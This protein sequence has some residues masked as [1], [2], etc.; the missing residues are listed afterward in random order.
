MSH[1]SVFIVRFLLEKINIV[2]QKWTKI[3]HSEQ[4]GDLYM[5]ELKGKKVLVTGATQGIGFD[6]AKVLSE[7]GALVYVNGC[8]SEEKTKNA[9]AKIPGSIPVT[10]DLALKDCAEKLFAV[11]GPL[12]ILILNASVQ[13]RKNWL[14]I[15]DEEFDKQ[16]N[17]N[18][19]SSLKLIQKYAPYMAERN[20]GRIITIG[21]VQQKKPH[22]DMLVYAASKMAQLGMV[23][24]LALQLA[25]YG[26]TVNNVAPGVIETPRN[27]DALSDK[28]YA[29]KVIDSIPLGYAGAPKDISSPVL[30]LCSE[31]GGYITGEDI[32]VDGGMGL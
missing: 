10:C 4:K 2:S 21:S 16:M 24:N 8:T 20:Y 32:F 26:I 6:I 7:F 1:P 29:K 30:L 23:K 15:T 11:T 12:D 18:F 9:S 28:E 17:V 13:I 3:S 22:K 19:R 27:Y 14:E 25:P 31:E 5:F